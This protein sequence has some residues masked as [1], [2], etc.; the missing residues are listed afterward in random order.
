MHRHKADPAWIACT[1][2]QPD[3]GELHGP[4]TI[5]ATVGIVGD[6]SLCVASVASIR[7]APFVTSRFVV[8]S[9]GV[10]REKPCTGDLN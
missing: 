4:M 7:R 2:T 5:S 10:I 3:V 9:D 6:T 1:W 8:R